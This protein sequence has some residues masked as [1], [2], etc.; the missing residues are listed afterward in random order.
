VVDEFY[1]VRVDYFQHM[2]I[3]RGITYD[4][5]SI[6]SPGLDAEPNFEIRRLMLRNICYHEFYHEQESLP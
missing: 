2:K 5:L 1:E 6:V 3:T 4:C